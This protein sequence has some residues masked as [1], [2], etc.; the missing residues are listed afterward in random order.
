[1]W[2]REV[3]HLTDFMGTCWCRGPTWHQWTTAGLC[4]ACLPTSC[5]LTPVSSASSLPSSCRCY[6]LA[7][8]IVPSSLETQIQQRG[9]YPLLTIVSIHYIYIVY[10]YRINTRSSR[11][12]LPLAMYHLNINKQ[13]TGKGHGAVNQQKPSLHSFFNF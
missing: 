7:S 10:I 13:M 11:E 2:L 3:H 12:H 4:A 9:V 5:R 1:M 8:Y 6:P